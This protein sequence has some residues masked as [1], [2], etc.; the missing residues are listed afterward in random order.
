MSDFSITLPSPPVDALQ[1]IGEY[2]R[3]SENPYSA[4]CVA[5]TLLL[6]D[7][8]LSQRERIALIEDLGAI[9][10]GMPTSKRAGFKRSK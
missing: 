2:V 5:L 4:L 3:G 8:S 6:N 9:Q 10:F 7:Q 1:A